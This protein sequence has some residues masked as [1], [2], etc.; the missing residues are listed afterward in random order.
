MKANSEQLG[1]LQP[2]GE[3]LRPLQDAEVAELERMA[4]TRFPDSYR[5]FLA[6]NGATN[7]GHDVQ[8]RAAGP[9]PPRLSTSGL[10]PFSYFFGATGGTTQDCHSLAWNIDNYAGRIPASFVPIASDGGGNI[11]CIDCGNYEFG[12]V[13]YWDHENESDEDD[14]GDESV[15]NTH[16]V[17]ESFDDFMN[18]FEVIND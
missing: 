6:M 12:R 5:R 13:F 3:A 10:L 9:L 11:Y 17:A 1:G 4:C 2:L 7:F 14:A 16:L 15:Q 8:C 18:R